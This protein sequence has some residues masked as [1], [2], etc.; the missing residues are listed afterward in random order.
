M[1]FYFFEKT[2]LANG[3]TKKAA[4]QRKAAFNPIRMYEKNCIA[5]IY[6]IFLN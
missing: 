4:L 1:Y 2:F 3:L 6:G 5:T